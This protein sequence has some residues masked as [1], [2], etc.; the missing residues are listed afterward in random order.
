MKVLTSLVV[1]VSAV[2][3][4]YWKNVRQW[5]GYQSNG[6][7]TSVS[8]LDIRCNVGASTKSVS[9]IDVAAGSTLGFTA[10][11]SISHPGPLLVYLAKV[12]E[13]KTAANWDGSGNVWFK[14]Y[15]IGPKFGGSLSWPAMGQTNINFKI[16]SAT[17][18]GEYLVRV[19]SIALHSASGANGAQFY[20]SCGQ[21]N[22]TGGGSGKPTDLVAFP[23]AY[24]SS[25][26]GIMLNI[27]YPVPT[28]YAMPGP[29]V[30]S[31]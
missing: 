18:S 25:D 22:V 5:T 30:W 23:G 9:T 14:I 12:P 19:E 13:G 31:G 29:A 21:I 3:A 8:S 28:S 24:K 15:E 1:L 20:I 2:K 11:S 26:P 7:V 17:P 16:P 10:K 27:Y 4:H 6:P